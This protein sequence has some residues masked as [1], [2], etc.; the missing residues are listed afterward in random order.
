MTDN[1]A[2]TGIPFASHERPAGED[3]WTC[4]VRLATDSLSNVPSGVKRAADLRAD[5]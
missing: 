3:P 4:G 2:R 5:D 1:D